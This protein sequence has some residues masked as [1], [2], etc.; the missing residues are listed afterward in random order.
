MPVMGGL[1]GSLRGIAVSGRA[2]TSVRFLSKVSVG[3][4]VR[5]EAIASQLPTT[6]GRGALRFRGG[7]LLLVVTALVTGACSGEGT[8][9]TTLAPRTTSI[10][11]PTTT[12]MSSTTASSTASTATTA[13]TT[14]TST[15]APASL[16]SASW[17]RVS[18]DE[19]VF[20]GEDFQGMF[21]ITVG[22]PGLVAVGWD[23]SGEDI[24]AAVWTSS[25]GFV[26]SRVPGDETPLSGAGNQEM[27]GI[28]VG[29]PGLVAVGRD[30]L[31]GDQDAAVWTSPD[32]VTWSRVRH[33][34]A[35]FGGAGIQVMLAVAVGGPGLVAVG[36]D[37]SG[38]GDESG[39]DTVAAVWTS[40]DGVTWS[41]IQHDAAVF[42]AGILEMN[43]VTSGGPGLVA[44][45]WG[46]PDGDQDAAVWT[47]PD[48]VTWSRVRH[49]EAAFGGAGI[50]A[51]RGLA[52]GGP[53]LVA[54]G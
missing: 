6:R 20:G 2:S 35:A 53:G 37:G 30:G 26:W 24:D 22:G 36:W 11:S 3:R 52:V 19:S 12:A 45:G 10:V 7:R 48:G 17:S 39:G 46:G 43:G 8:A 15:A 34:E 50:Q 54:V 27:F 9:E 25:G 44:V 51:M 16:P 33:D 14:T 13:L 1:L 5:V 31:D 40:P 41:R 49:D 32:G 23:A 18:H 38:G 47:S 4:L 28:T 29:G 21:G 42:G